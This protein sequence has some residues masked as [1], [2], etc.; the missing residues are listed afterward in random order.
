M[1]TPEALANLP[2]LRCYVR[3][4]G[5]GAYP[6]DWYVALCLDL[7]LGGRGETPEVAS[8]HLWRAIATSLRVCAH[9]SGTATF[10][11]RAPWWCW[12]RYCWLAVNGWLSRR[13]LTWKIRSS[14]DADADV[15]TLRSGYER[16]TYETFYAD[17]PSQYHLL[18]HDR[19]S[20]GR[21]VGLTLFGLGPAR[22]VGTMLVDALPE[23]ESE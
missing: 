21:V 19:E 17:G 10:L 4:E 13:R 16:D 11:R 15:L 5:R 22:V 12:L 18:I 7:S 9:P 2:V 20:D 14:Y 6:R 3:R 8:R 23:E 1:T